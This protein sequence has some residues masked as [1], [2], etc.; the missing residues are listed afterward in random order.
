ML[1]IQ[2]RDTVPTFL[3]PGSGFRDGKKQILDP[4][5]GINIP[6]H[7]S[8]SLVI[9]FL[10]LNHL[11]GFVPEKIR[12]LPGGEGTSNNNFRRVRSGLCKF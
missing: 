7:I 1:R 8:D 5:S 10:G 11:I 6:N 3:T 4:G 9:N 2:I 12:L